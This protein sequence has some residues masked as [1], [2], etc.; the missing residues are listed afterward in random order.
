MGLLERVGKS[1]RAAIEASATERS[2]RPTELIFG[3]D[4]RT[5]VG[6]V[7]N[8]LIRVF[9]VSAAGYSVTHRNVSRSG[10]VGIGALVDRPDFVIAQ[11]VGYSVVMQLDLHL[12]RHLAATDLQFNRA[13]AIEVH[14]RLLDTASEIQE[15]LTGSLTRR[16]ARELLDIAAQLGEGEPLSIPVT[17]EALAES[18][19]SSREAVSRQLASLAKQ[20]L[21]RQRGRGRLELLHPE[22]LLLNRD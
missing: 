10:V 8:G 4:N 6:I 7:G 13:V 17:H 5:W 12:V 1:T 3:P 2:F 22:R 18:V 9:S 14:Q 19:G 21:V 20:G 15:R 11:S 16:L